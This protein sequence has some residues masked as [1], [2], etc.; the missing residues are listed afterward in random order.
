MKDFFGI[1]LHTDS[2]DYD[3]FP[4]VVRCGSDF[5]RDESLS[6][7]REN[8][9]YNNWCFDPYVA[10]VGFECRFKNEDD[11]IIFKLRFSI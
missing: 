6:W 3:G 4:I 11:A 5:L 7:C 2:R 8:I 1:P 9:P 10:G